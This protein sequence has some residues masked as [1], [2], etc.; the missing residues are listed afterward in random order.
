MLIGDRGEQHGVMPIKQAL[1]FARDIGTDLVEVSPN[2]DPQYA[3]CW[4]MA[5]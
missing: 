2:T 3:D 4:I 5:N 1:E